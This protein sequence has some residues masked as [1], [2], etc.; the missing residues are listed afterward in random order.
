VRVQELSAVVE[1]ATRRALELRHAYVGSEHLL[2][3]LTDAPP[4]IAKE[5]LA[6][7][8][9]SAPAVAEVVREVVIAEEDGRGD[10]ALPLTSHARAAVDLAPHEA[11]GIG[12]GDNVRAEHLLMALMQIVAMH[13]QSVGATVLRTLRVDPDDV[14]DRVADRLTRGDPTG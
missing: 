2:L 10:R 7:F 12:D 3:A 1:D 6:Q 11:I 13:D 14:R 4:G 8:G 5:A 9:L